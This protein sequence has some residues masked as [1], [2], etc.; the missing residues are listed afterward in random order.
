MSSDTTQIPSTQSDSQTPD[1]VQA[2]WTVETVSA[3]VKFLYQCKTEGKISSGYREAGVVEQGGRRHQC[4][5]RSRW[6]MS[7]K[8]KNKW[9]TDI[10]IKWKHWRKLATIRIWLE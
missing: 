2:R 6:F 5:P 4:D 10:K 8:C 3:L 1:S 9:L 7:A